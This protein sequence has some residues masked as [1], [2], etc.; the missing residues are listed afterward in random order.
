MNRTYTQ[1]EIYDYL[2]A[3]PY[4][5]E[6]WIGDL[7]NMNGDDYIFLNYTSE[8]NIPSD[9]AGCYITSVQIDVYTRDFVKRKQIVDY[10]KSL[11]QFS[12]TYMPSN[13]GNYFVAQMST[14]LFINEAWKS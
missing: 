11:S 8:R 10:V 13:E 7:Y 5:A 14:E 3:N 4:N 9:N 6:V 1:K 2:K 12:I